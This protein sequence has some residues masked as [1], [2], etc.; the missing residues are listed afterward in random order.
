MQRQRCK[1]T[2]CFEIIYHSHEY[3]GPRIIRTQRGKFGNWSKG[4]FEDKSES[5]H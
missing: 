2:G 5:D 3:S 1:R 4:E